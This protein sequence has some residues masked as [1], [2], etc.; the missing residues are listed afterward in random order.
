MKRLTIRDLAS[1]LSLSTSTVSR[2]LSDHPDISAATKKR[3]R[4]AADEFN[5]TT[6]VH[7]KL[8][9]KQHSGLIAVILPEVNMFFTP[10]LVRGIVK[11]ITPTNYSLFTFLSNDSYKREKEI[12]KHCLSWAVEGVLMSLSNQTYDLSHLMPLHNAKIKCVL[13]DK[14]IKNERFPSL[15]IDSEEA[16]YRAVSHLIEN[17]HRNILGVFGNP[18][19]SITVDRVIGYRK[20]MTEHG[21]PII[22]EN[23]VHVDTNSNLDFILP[24]ILN[25]NKRLTAMFTMSDELLA[26]SLFQLNRLGFHIPSD[27]SVISISDGAYPYL[28]YPQVTHIKDS[29]SKMGKH[30]TKLLLDCIQNDDDRMPSQT[31]ITTKLVELDSVRQIRIPVV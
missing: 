20:A 24:P 23:I 1:I 9:R 8:F 6:N 2:A 17:G 15:M 18:N 3:V 22:E 11:T 29:G 5:Y 25:H 10:S 21:L 7:A 30:A 4:E 28:V 27:M 19:L 14:T 13:F 31:V 16:S 26:K 12:V